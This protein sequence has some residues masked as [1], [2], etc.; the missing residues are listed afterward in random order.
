MNAVESRQMGPPRLYLYNPLL[1]FH[2]IE[3]MNSRTRMALSAVAIAVAVLLSA[4]G[5]V[6]GDYQA[7]A[8]GYYHH[9]WHHYWWHPWWHYHW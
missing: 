3:L 7:Y 4:S 8:Y 5:P 1:L 9:W 6:F 2:I